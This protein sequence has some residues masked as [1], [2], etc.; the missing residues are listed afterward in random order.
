MI[1]AVGLIFIFSLTI[2]NNQSRAQEPAPTCKTT[3]C[4]SDFDKRK[5]IHKPVREGKCS[6]CHKAVTETHPNDETVDFTL[7][8]ERDEIC[9]ACHKSFGKFIKEK[10]KYLHTPVKQ[11]DCYACHDPHASDNWMLLKKFFSK[12]YYLPFKLEYYALCFDCHNKEIVTEKETD[13][14]TNFRNGNFNLH[15]KHVNRDPK[16]R[17]CNSCHNIHASGQAMIIRPD[18]PFRKRDKKG[19]YFNLSIHYK[20]TKTGGSCAVS[21]HRNRYYDRE[22]PVVNK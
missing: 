11:K 5:N 6:Q 7:T 9:Y 4:H 17:N 16:G 21:C 15:F 1:F 2:F 19:Y 10:L 13:R 18:V 3:D 12:R 8:G 22:N 20:K 14:L